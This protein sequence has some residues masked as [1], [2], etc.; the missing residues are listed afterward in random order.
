MQE[1]TSAKVR[2]SGEAGEGEGEVPKDAFVST[3]GASHSRSPGPDNRYHDERNRQ[4]QT[5]DQAAHGQGS[6]F[7]HHR[8]HSTSD[9]RQGD[10]GQDEHHG[11]APEIQGQS[12]HQQFP[13]HRILLSERLGGDFHRTFAFPSAVREEDVQAS[14]EN[15]VLSLVVPKRDLEGR[16]E[17]GRRIPVSQGKSWTG[18]DAREGVGRD[19]GDGHG[20]HSLGQRDVDV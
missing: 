1:G 4:G 3:V 16:R 20:G 6:H 17:R 2:S 8:R 10:H 18:W 11:A 12:H 5:Q 14:M 19:K 15:G 9:Q 7:Q 13:D